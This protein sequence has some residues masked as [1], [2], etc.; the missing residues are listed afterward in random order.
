M[1]IICLIISILTGLSTLLVA[2]PATPFLITFEQPDGSIFH[3]YLKGDEYFSWIESE[4]KLI[5][6]KNEA[7]RFFEFA[8]VKRDEE[9]RLKLVPS[10]VSVIQSD[11]S[12]PKAPA[13]ISKISRDQLSEIWKSKIAERRS[14]KIMP[15]KKTQ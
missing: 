12:A 2:V 7:S 9:N 13:N 15:A 14:L 11:Q 10:G 5:I 3:A 6:I 4:N 8:V 1:K